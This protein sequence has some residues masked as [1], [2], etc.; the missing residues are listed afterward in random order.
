MRQVLVRGG[1]SAHPLHGGA[2]GR[3]PQDVAGQGGEVFSIMVSISWAYSY[4]RVHQTPAAGRPASERCS[5]HTVTGTPYVTEWGNFTIKSIKTFFTFAKVV[6]E[7]CDHVT[8]IQRALFDVPDPFLNPRVP[9]NA[10]PSVN[11]DL[12]KERLLCN[13]GSTSIEIGKKDKRDT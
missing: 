9:C 1:Q 8:T 2:A 13:V 12:W 11:L 5:T 3:H 7:N 10:L 6:C 4:V